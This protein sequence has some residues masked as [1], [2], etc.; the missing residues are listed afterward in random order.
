M[1][2]PDPGAP[3]KNYWDIKGTMNGECWGNFVLEH[4]VK[5]LLNP[6]LEVLC[7]IKNGKPI[8]TCQIAHGTLLSIM[9]QPGW[10][11]GLGRMDTRICMAESLCCS[12]ET[13]TTLLIAYT[14]TQNKKSKVW[15]RK[16]KSSL[17]AEAI[18]SILWLLLGIEVARCRYF[19]VPDPHKR[20]NL[21][22]LDLTWRSP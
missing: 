11:R 12:P 1:E 10:E 9:W 13:T 18:L 4:S 15:K 7:Y 19:L 14:P 22:N 8:R 3:W 16:K 6:L 21:K 5:S 17:K 2:L 20:L